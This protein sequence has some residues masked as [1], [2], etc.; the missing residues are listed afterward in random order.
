M[1]LQLSSGNSKL[2]IQLPKQKVGDGTNFVIIL[3]GALLEQAEALIRMGLTPNEIAEGYEKALEKALEILPN[4]VCQTVVDVQDSDVITKAIKAAIMSKQYGNESFLTPLITEACV[5]I[6]PDKKTTF[7]VDNVRVSKILGGSLYQSQVVQ[8]M[9]F[10]RQVEGDITRAEKAKIAVY[11]CPIDSVQTETKGTVLIQSSKELIDFSRGEENML[12]KE[13]A[14]IAATGVKVIVSGGKIGDLCLHYLN[15]YGIMGV[16][17]QS[18][19]DLRRLCKSINA[20]ALPRLTPPSPE[21]MGYADNIYTDEFGDTAVV[22]FRQ[23]EKESRIAT[24]IVRG[25]T[26][27]FLDDIERAIDDGINNFKV[28]SRDG[29]LVPGAGATEVE[30][31]RQINQFAD[32]CP[33][34]DQYAI[35]KF[36]QALETFPS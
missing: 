31:A 6:L 18:K 29:R 35:Q 34:L 30:L 13:I 33:G 12:E 36:A 1:M 20:T 11:T 3:A 10:K 9:V 27:N 23:D 17:L 14:A 21:E 16:R 25:T 24:I 26:D 7:N 2:N 28:L 4:L 15:K 19:F 8:G 32:K 5:A 22:I